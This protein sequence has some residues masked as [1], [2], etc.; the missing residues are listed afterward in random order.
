MSVLSFRLSVTG[1]A[2]KA[3]GK[4]K[5]TPYAVRYILRIRFVFLLVVF[6]L[7]GSTSAAL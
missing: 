3:V 1:Q 7:L 4:I 6:L 2:V 5:I